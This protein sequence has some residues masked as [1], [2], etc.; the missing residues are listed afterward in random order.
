M[1][2][3]LKL[4][5]LK[6]RICQTTVG[7]T[8]RANKPKNKPKKKKG[9]TGAIKFVLEFPHLCAPDAVA[10]PSVNWRQRDMFV[11]HQVGGVFI[12]LVFSSIVCLSFVALKCSNCISQMLVPWRFPLVGRCLQERRK[13]EIK[14]ARKARGERSPD[15]KEDKEEEEN[16]N[17]KKNRESD[18]QN[19]IS[20]S[21]FS[22]LNLCRN[23][24]SA[25]YAL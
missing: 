13:K 14:R 4:A 8:R 5:S 23:A 15:W 17:V 7:Q 20:H 9:T 21:F 1:P 12:P 19:E 2:S 6:E 18:G 22:A 11:Q 16:K 25:I 10:G 24:S 3:F